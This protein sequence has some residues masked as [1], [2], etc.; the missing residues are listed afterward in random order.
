MA[1]DG[2]ATFA[3]VE[4]INRARTQRYMQDAAPGV[5]AQCSC[6]CT[7]LHRVVGDDPYS[8]PAMDE[9]PW[10][11]PDDP[12]SAEFFGLYPLRIQGLN[13]STRTATVIQSLGPGGSVIGKRRATKDVRVRGI[14]LAST[15]RGMEYGNDWLNSVLDGAC[16]SCEGDAFCYFSSCPDP[17]AVPE[18]EVSSEIDLVG[19]STDGG[20][21]DGVT[22]TP[23]ATWSRL[24]TP[25]LQR[26]LPCKVTYEWVIQ[27]SPGTTVWLRVGG[28]GEGSS[29]D[30]S[31]VLDGDEQRLVV[32]DRG[33]SQNWV[34]SS[35]S[36]GTSSG[37]VP[38][39]TLSP[40]ELLMPSD[41]RSSV[42]DRSLPPEVTVH[43]VTVTH[44]I[45]HES[46]SAAAGTYLRTLRD[47]SAVEGPSVIQ[48]RESVNFRLREVDFTLVAEIPY[49]FTQEMPVVALHSGLER[50]TTTGSIKKIAVEIPDC[51]DQPATM[52]AVGPY[53]IIDPDL[54]R[55]PPPPI[56]EPLE[57]APGSRRPDDHYL[58]TI[59]DAALPT[60]TDMVPTIR[61]GTSSTPIRN[62]RVRFFPISR[63]GMS[64]KDL[65]GCDACGGFNI[66]YIPPNAEMTLDGATQRASIRFNGTHEQH[67]ATHLLSSD[68]GRVFTWPVLS[69]G[70]G[71][72]AAI[73]MD[74]D[75][76]PV[77]SLSLVARR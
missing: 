70:M 48:D 49:I 40:S 76:L 32:E 50:T 7:E 60:W 36:V 2:Y 19:L 13:D 44:T 37:L 8:N 25:R 56:L 4:I 11:D 62:V 28:E 74:L 75:L 71:Y 27:G 18:Q 31:F 68:G 45:E 77:L 61:I 26:P 17:S 69:C 64:H 39:G 41:T 52:P 20:N 12:A 47:V 1:W 29:T 65:S 10:Y 16:T 46:P 3:G 15:D 66:T 59:P 55:I 35:L 24:V 14:L 6:D 38:S 30:T 42:L 73:D 21:F 22:F 33:F 57:V 23:E 9:A 51:T 34:S 63:Y 53:G 5:L 54:P 72:F 67:H 43:S 58:I